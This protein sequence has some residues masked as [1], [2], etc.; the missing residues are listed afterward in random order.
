MNS[1]EVEEVL[2]SI[3]SEILGV[4]TIDPMASFLDLGGNSI[5]AEQIAARVCEAM[6]VSLRGSQILRHKTLSNIVRLLEQQMTDPKASGC[7]A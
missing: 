6:P 5:A 1:V 4:E 3:W 7:A 2:K